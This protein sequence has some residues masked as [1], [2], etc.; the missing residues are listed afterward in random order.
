[1]MKNKTDS[2]LLLIRNG[3]AMTLRQQLRLNV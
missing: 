1:M 2:L 3:Q